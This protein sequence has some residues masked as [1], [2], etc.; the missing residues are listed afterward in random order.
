[1]PAIKKGWAALNDAVT[2]DGMIGWVQQVGY[3]PDKVAPN[4]TQFY[5]AGAFL[6]A[7]AGMLELAE[8]GYLN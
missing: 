8:K 2:D 6:L 1:M 5:G 7:G 4:E 3:A